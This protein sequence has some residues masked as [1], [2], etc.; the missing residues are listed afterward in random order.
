MFNIKQKNDTIVSKSVVPTSTARQLAKALLD[1]AKLKAELDKVAKDYNPKDGGIPTSQPV[2]P[3]GIVQSIKDIENK[4]GSYSQK[5]VEKNNDLQRNRIEGH[6]NHL[7][8]LDAKAIESQTAYRVEKNYTARKPGAVVLPTGCPTERIQAA[9]GKENTDRMNQG[10]TPYTTYQTWNDAPA[11]EA[12]RANEDS[13]ARGFTH[14]SDGET[15]NTSKAVA[16]YITKQKYYLLRDNAISYILNTE[17]RNG[18]VRLVK[19]QSMFG[20]DSSYSI[21]GDTKAHP[22]INLTDAEHADII[23]AQPSYEALMSVYVQA[24]NNDNLALNVKT[25]VSVW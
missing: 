20:M 4:Q 18:L 2:G 9:I 19:D 15:L 11:T 25:A 12:A 17:N 23:K 13:A 6:A 22:F 24:L 8:E 5:V 16:T 14:L 7:K 10:L 3:K 1:N 21:K